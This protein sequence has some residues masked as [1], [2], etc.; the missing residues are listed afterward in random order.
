MQSNK[1]LHKLSLPWERSYVITEVLYLGAYKLKTINGEVFT[2]A[3][4]IEQLRRF[5]P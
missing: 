3:W 2:N 4:N 1:Y 5:Y